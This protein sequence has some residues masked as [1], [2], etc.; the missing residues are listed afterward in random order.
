MVMRPLPVRCPVCESPLAAKVLFCPACATEVS[1]RFA[2]NEFAL[3]P[4]EHLDFLRLFVKARGNLK[5]VERLLGVS[6][7]TVRAR[8]DALLRALGY[9]DE[10][11]PE[12]AEAARLEV[13]EAL[14]KGEISVEEAVARLRGGKS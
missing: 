13:L 3:L 12:G 9:E 14:R 10:A 6:Y 5:E 4:K 8:L 7:P 1:G 2:L 11:E